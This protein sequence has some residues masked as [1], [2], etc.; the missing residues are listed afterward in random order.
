MKDRGWATEEAKLSE[1]IVDIV[2]YR[3]HFA[4]LNLTKPGNWWYKECKCWQSSQN[5]QGLH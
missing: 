2:E 5:S 3:Q 1:L 4:L